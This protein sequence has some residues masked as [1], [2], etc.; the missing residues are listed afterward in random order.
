MNSLVSSFMGTAEPLLTPCR[1]HCF[2]CSSSLDQALGGESS[3]LG[4]LETGLTA[5]A[6]LTFFCTLW[7]WLI[8]PEKQSVSCLSTSQINLSLMKSLVA[9]LL[10]PQS[11]LSILPNT[12]FPSSFSFPLL[13]ISGSCFSIFASGQEFNPL[14]REHGFHTR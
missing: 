11:P 1:L 4:Y 9:G 14:W 6:T 8:K 7:P 13:H 2:S 12:S 5:V 10:R 3:S